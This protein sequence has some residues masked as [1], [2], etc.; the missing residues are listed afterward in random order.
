MQNDPDSVFRFAF[1]NPGGFPVDQ[2]NDKSTLIE[3]MVLPLSASAIGFAEVDVNWNKLDACD[4]LNER[5]HGWWRKASVNVAHYA[6]YAP[7]QN[8]SS[9]AHQYGGVA[10]LSVNDGASRLHS[11]GADPTG[12]GRWAWTRYQENMVMCYG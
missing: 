3:E 11:T 1:V 5:I 2:R 7:K 12:L 6:S 4:N 9:S 8:L 10:L